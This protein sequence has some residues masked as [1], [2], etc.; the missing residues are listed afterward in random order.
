MAS[1]FAP[2][3]RRELLRLGLGA[4]A[5]A[6]LP[7]LL[8]GCRAA[9]RAQLWVPARFLPTAWIK[10]LPAGWW[11]RQLDEPGAVLASRSAVPPPDLV[12]LSDGWAAE[13][14]EAWQPFPA[15]DLLGRLAPWA[16]PASRLFGGDSAP[17]VAYPWA[18]APWVVLLRSRPDLQ[19]RAGEGWS[20]LL[21]PSL[22]GR[23]VLPSSPRICMAVMGGDF[24]RVRLLRQQAL[25]YDEQDGL[26]LLLSGAA[27]AAVLPLC[28]IVPLL[29]RDQR[30]GVIWPASGAP[31]TWQLLLRPHGSAQPPPLPWLAEAQTEPLLTTLL[32]G[33]WVPPLPAGVLEPVVRRF[34]RAIASLLLPEPGL[35]QRCW[36][37]PPLETGERLALQSLWDA[38]APDRRD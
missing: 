12:G 19:V 24:E 30:L 9:P 6:G 5:A 16:L 15:P 14:P 31:L 38:A 32:A 28:Q 11:A 34:P 17:A 23:L 1:T 36:S 3:S 22:R 13:A 4:G 35:L 25:A 8:G 29:R 27:D 37:L 10:A 7:L 33:G 18:Y 26:N 20:L 21:D 2:L